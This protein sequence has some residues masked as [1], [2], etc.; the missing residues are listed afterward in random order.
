M[1]K[2]KQGGGGEGE[3]VA[4]VINKI[5][6]SVR[7]D[8]IKSAVNKPSKYVNQSWMS[9]WMRGEK[10]C[11]SEWIRIQRVEVQPV[12]ISLLQRVWIRHVCLLRKHLLDT[13]TRWQ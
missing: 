2:K 4:V 12:D 6:C 5:N 8:V 3:D 7:I 10:I 9:A 11:K 1:E 13:S